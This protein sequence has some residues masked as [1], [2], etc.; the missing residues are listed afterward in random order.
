MSTVDFLLDV[1]KVQG[2]HVSLIFLILIILLTI[3]GALFVFVTNFI[4]LNSHFLNKQEFEKIKL[5]LLS[6]PTFDKNKIIKIP[7]KNQNQEA[8]LIIKTNLDLFQFLTLFLY[9]ILGRINVFA[10]KHFLSLYMT[11]F[12][13]LTLHS[14]FSHFHFFK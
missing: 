2:V 13:I 3:N 14:V 11:T 1:F 4:I 7:S 8:Y 5:E 6:N 9:P 10:R 12:L